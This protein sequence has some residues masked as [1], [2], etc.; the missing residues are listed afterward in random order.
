MTSC[1]S[2]AKRPKPPIRQGK[3]RLLHQQR[4]L[5]YHFHLGSEQIEFP[6]NTR[7]VFTKTAIA[8]TFMKNLTLL[9]A[10]ALATGLVFGT[11]QPA[12]ALS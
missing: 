11:M 9:S 8:T 4:H 10:I 12:S 2:R 1:T 3:Y 6:Y 7:E 5:L